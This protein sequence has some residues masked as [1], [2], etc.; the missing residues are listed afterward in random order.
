MKKVSPVEALILGLSL[1]L[2]LI[3]LPLEAFYLD[4]KEDGIIGLLCVGIGWLGIGT[5]WSYISWLA[6][7]L[8]LAS[9][10]IPF[11][12]PIP[13]ITMAAAS[14]FLALLFI[15][16]DSVKDNSQGKL[17]II[18]GLGPD[19]LCWVLSP[20]LFLLGNVIWLIVR[21][22]KASRKISARKP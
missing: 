18:T 17:S 3:S 9:W 22:Q 11:K 1:L 14:A 4:H 19:Y 10:I 13:K 21:E 20:L 8:L 16:F 12:F 15:V 2:Y 7:P 5:G 6:N